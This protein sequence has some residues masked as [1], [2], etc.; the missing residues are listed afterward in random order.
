MVSQRRRMLDYLRG[1]EEKR[2]QDV[3]ARLGIRK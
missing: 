3:I 2:Y 1:K